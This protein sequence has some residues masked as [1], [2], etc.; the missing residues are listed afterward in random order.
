MKGYW[1]RPDATAK[2]LKN[3]WL[4]TGDVGIMMPNGNFKIVDRKKDMILVSG[5]NVYP[6]EVEEVVSQHPKVM[7]CA[8]IGV[9]DERT[10]EKI[11]IFVVKKEESLTEQELMEHCKKGLTGYKRPKALEWRKELPKSV[12][13]KIL[14]KD[15]RRP[16]D[17]KGG[18]DKKEGQEQEYKRIEN[19]DKNMIE[20]LCNN[21]GLSYYK[22]GKYL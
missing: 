20:E 1:K 16:E 10:G 13:G 8:A 21:K 2:I 17:I 18:K 12:V 11:K 19:F 4:S 9:P 14:R 7:E 22:T 15:L 5:F 3:G 6:N